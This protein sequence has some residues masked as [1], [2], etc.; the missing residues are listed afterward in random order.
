MTQYQSSTTVEP[1]AKS[2]PKLDAS[3]HDQDLRRLQ[4]IVESQR[5]TIEALQKDLRRVHRQLDAHA[6]V[7]NSMSRR[8]G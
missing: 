5:A 2:N 8:N 7:I 1:T 4:D 3:K 6:R